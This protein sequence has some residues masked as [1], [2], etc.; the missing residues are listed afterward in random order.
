MIAQIIPTLS[1]DEI[2]RIGVCLIVIAWGVQVVVNI[3]RAIKPYQPPIKQEEMYVT[4][5]QFDTRINTL[6]NQMNA[7]FDKIGMQV[8]SKLTV[9]TSDYGVR[10]KE[11]T[12]YMHES[13]HRT[14]NALQNV[15]VAQAEIKG[16]LSAKR[17]TSEENEE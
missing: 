5:A 17:R 2:A 8:E 13:T 10:L 3:Y 16:I 15:V 6:E 14:N 11:L 1:F 9:F 7:K 4:H 12:Q